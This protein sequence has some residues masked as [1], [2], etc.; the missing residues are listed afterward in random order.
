MS[1]FFFAIDAIDEQITNWKSWGDEKSGGRSA[2]SGVI[3]YG[4]HFKKV[5]AI[6]E[7]AR[8]RAYRKVNE[9]LILIYIDIGE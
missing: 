4:E 6:I 8:E 1:P 9:E 3:R 2:M 7:S 5:V